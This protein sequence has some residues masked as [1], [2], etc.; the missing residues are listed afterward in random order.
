MVRGKTGVWA[1]H[2]LEL[3]QPIPVHWTQDPQ[4]S[5]VSFGE[6]DVVNYSLEL[7][8][9]VGEFLWGVLMST[10]QLEFVGDVPIFKIVG[11]AKDFVV[12]VFEVFV[13]D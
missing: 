9:E 7:V 13:S 5:H 3:L 11:K 6:K 1:A 10:G 8:C 4:C 12:D 2:Y